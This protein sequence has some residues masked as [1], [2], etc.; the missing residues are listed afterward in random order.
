M[1]FDKMTIEELESRKVAISEEL[2]QDGADLDALE[3]EVRGIN[4]E[5]ETR[6]ETE[7]KK[8]EIRAAVATGAGETI[9]VPEKTEVQK[10]T[11]EE[12]RSSQEYVNAFAEYI[13]TNDD[14]ECRALLTEN[15]AGGTV[16]VPT[17]VYDIVKTAWNREG[18]MSRVRKAYLKGNLK[19][20]F[21]ISGDPAAIH[22]EGQAVNEEALVL[23]TVSLVPE[24]IKKWISISDEVLDMRGEAFLNYIYDELAYRIAKKAAD[25]LIAKIK[26]CGTASTTTMVAVPAFK[27]ATIGMG[28]IAKAISQLSDE[29]ANPVIM[30]NKLTWSDFKAVQYAA[31]YGADPFEGLPVVFNDTIAAASVATTGVPY[32]IVGDLEQGA[33][34]NFPAGQ[35]IQFKFDEMTL[36][37]S[38]LVR[39]IGRM[40]VALGVVAPNAFVKITK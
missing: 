19:V 4:S 27:E 39:V 6:R 30:M 29:A 2:E 33:L 3:A 5:L 12:I 24:T 38:D 23:G 32:V 9:A 40:P 16:A 31:S 25:E 15:V 34:A 21:E 13:K 17:I 18:I 36:A 8:V 37:T 26:A 20:G 22:T 7:A 10:M 1:E 11:N 28:T 14:T 35:E